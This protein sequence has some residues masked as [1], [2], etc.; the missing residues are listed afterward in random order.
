VTDYPYR[1]V[2]GKAGRI[3][4]SAQTDQSE[5]VDATIMKPRFT[6]RKPRPTLE[7]SARRAVTP[8]YRSDFSDGLAAHIPHIVNLEYAAQGSQP[9]S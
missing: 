6:L 1:H 8:R 4:S 2:R 3:H 9:T 7:Q 5:I